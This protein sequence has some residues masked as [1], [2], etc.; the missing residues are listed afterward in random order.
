[1]SRRD[2]IPV[3]S[4]VGPMAPRLLDLHGAAAYL[5]GL[6]V[7]TLRAMIAD[8]KLPTVRPPSLRRPDEAMRRV[9]V[10][11]RDLDVLI[12]RWKDGRDV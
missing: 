4:Q 6:S 5:G 2:E 10:D 12:A 9:L 3:V 7:W 1:M 8:G 11:V